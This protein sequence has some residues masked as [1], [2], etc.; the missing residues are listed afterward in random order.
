MNS[1]DLVGKILEPADIVVNG[2]RP[3]D[4]QVHN[5]KLYD[6]VLAKGTLGI[7]ESYMD[8][9]WDC[10]EIDELVNRIIRIR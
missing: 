8:G 4:I 1:K 7:G 6:R 10:G 9:W 2:D 3:W 5:E